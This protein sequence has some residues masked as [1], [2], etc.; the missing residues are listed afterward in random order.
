M[1]RPSRS[2]EGHPARRIRQSPKAGQTPRH[3]AARQ[4]GPQRG[5]RDRAETPGPG[6]SVEQH[7]HRVWFD[8]SQAT[9][10]SAFGKLPY[11]FMIRGTEAAA[12]H[13]LLE[14]CQVDL[15]TSKWLEN[16]DEAVSCTALLGWP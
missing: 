4:L 8:K 11:D 16:F 12:E 5:N 13:P 15:G 7:K 9:K 3:L 14:L 1:E 6:S 2:H 10:E